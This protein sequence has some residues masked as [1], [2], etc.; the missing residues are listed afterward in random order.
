[1]PSKL[2]QRQEPPSE[3]SMRNDDLATVHEIAELLHVPDTWVYTRTRC[4]G[5]ERLPYYKIGKYLRFSR[6]EVLQWVE[7]QRGNSLAPR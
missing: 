4:R 7:H 3:Y 1:M 6:R 5:R 2:S